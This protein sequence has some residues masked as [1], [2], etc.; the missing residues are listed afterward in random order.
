M[1]R[2]YNSAN[3]PLDPKIEKI[4]KKYQAK[5]DLI[6]SYG[7]DGT[8]LGAERDYPGIPK[9]PIRSSSVCQKCRHLDDLDN[10]LS[11]VSQHQLKPNQYTK[12]QTN[13][14]GHK[15]ISLNEFC[16]KSAKPNTALR[17]SYTVGDIAT[18]DIIA[19]G[20]IVSTSFGSTG[21]FK[22]I[23]RTIFFH[24]IGVAVI[25]PTIPINNIIY[26]KTSVISITIDRVEA[27][28]FS[29]NDPQI[30]TINPGQIIV[31]KKATK[32]ALIY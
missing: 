30:I 16:L 19:D 7:G 4:V 10:I 20:I 28:L 31:I 6:I 11:S 22:S 13:I 21:Y 27:H 2:I 29:D 8:L 24:G 3:R 12:L 15:L 14:N 18:K 5:L 9:L 26:P 1:I 17:F 23:T 25:N 32:P